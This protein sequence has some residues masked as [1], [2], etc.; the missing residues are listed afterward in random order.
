VST[1]AYLDGAENSSE[2]GFN[3]RTVQLVGIPTELSQ[4]TATSRISRPTREIAAL[5]CFLFAFS[6]LSRPNVQIEIYNFYFFIDSEDIEQNVTIRC[7]K[8]LD[9]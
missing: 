7:Y 6:V 5:K 3:T 2:L 9:R 1:R 4:P 8:D